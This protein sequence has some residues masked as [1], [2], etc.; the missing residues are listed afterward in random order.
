MSAIAETPARSLRTTLPLETGD[1]LGRA[2]FERRYAAMPGVKKA[3]LIEGVVYIGSPVRFESHGSPHGWVMTWLGVY[4]AATPGVSLGDNVT[5]RLDADNEV[6]S[7]ALLRLDPARGGQS[8]IGSDDYVEGPPELVVEIA[9]SSASYDLHDK[10]RI[11]RRTGV[12]EYL[13]WVVAER[14]LEW[15]RLQDGEYLS[16]LPDTDGVTRS[17]VLPGLALAGEALLAGDLARVLEVLQAALTGPEHTAFIA[18]SQQ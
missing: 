14:R 9:A 16:L 13:V 12:R 3:E 15:W 11:Y 10:K 6:Q 7:D 17:T 2:E 8:R 4:M 1:H 5:V 18:S